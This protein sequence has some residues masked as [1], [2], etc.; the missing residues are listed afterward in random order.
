MADMHPETSQIG[1][2]TQ[3]R[4]LLFAEQLRQNQARLHGY[5]YSL[6]RDVHD[7]DDLLQ[8]TILILWNKFDSFDDSR[9][10][11]AWACGIARGEV[12]NFLRSRARRR[13]V[14]SDDVNLALAEAHEAVIEDDLEDRRIALQGCMQKLRDVD[15]EFVQACYAE[16]DGVQR[17]ADREGRSTQSVYNS[18]RRIRRALFECIERSLG[19]SRHPETDA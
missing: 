4:N 17:V 2:D 16:S 1:P 6:M 15:R 3:R 19:R 8:Q 5:L 13:L 10:F 14:F 7:A 12:S 11:F 9:S 18:M